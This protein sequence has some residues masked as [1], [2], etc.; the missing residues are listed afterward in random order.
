MRD[1][2]VARTALCLTLALACLFLH[3]CTPAEDKKQIVLITQGQEGYYWQNL[4]EGAR[5]AAADHGCELEQK[6]IG[7]DGSLTELLAQASASDASLIALAVP[8][9]GLP[10]VYN[11]AKPLALLGAN[12]NGA[13]SLC[14]TYGEEAMIGKRI[15]QLLFGNNGLQSELLLLTDTPEY[16]L[17]NTFEI[18]IRAELGVGGGHIYERQYATDTSTAYEL[19]LRALQ[20]KPL[21]IDCIVATTQA[22]TVGALRAVRET[23]LPVRVIGTDI[24]REIA[25]GLQDKIVTFS[26]VYSAYAYGYTGID[27]AIRLLGGE[28]G[29]ETRTLFDAVYVSYENMFEDD[30]AV[31]LFDPDE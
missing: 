13:Y 6:V 30:L 2:Q 23:D 17:S 24:N 20:Q 4:N 11:G 7:E 28:E 27:N 25:L 29:L 12:D 18:A 16:S 14:R 3:G 10:K 26:V 5:L 9:T 22:A 8:Q 1:H 19:S 21:M 15:V 31:Y